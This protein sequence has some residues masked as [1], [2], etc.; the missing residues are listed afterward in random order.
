MFSGHSLIERGV[1]V[2]VES[3]ASSL[4]SSLVWNEQNITGSPMRA[5]TRGL[6]LDDPAFPGYRQGRNR[7]T[8]NMDI[9]A[10]LSNPQTTGGRRYDTLVIAERHD[11]VNTLMWEDT[12]RYARHYLE[13]MVA[14]NAA[15]NGYLYHAWLGI[16]DKNDPWQ[17][18]N[19]ERT[20]A[21]AWQC[22]AARV[23]V[24]LAAE[25]RAERMRYLPAGLALADLVDAAARGGVAGISAGSA[26]ATVDQL[27]TDALHPSALG[28]Y[29]LSLVTYASVY[30][31]SPVGAWAPQGVTAQQAA[32]LQQMAWQSV[33][34]HYNANAT[35]PSPSQCQAA[36][37]EQ[38]CTA[39]ASYSGNPNNAAGCIARFGEASQN[40]PFHYDAASDRAYWFPA[41]R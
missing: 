4:G 38:V 13:R 20:A 28:E 17:W 34:N 1:A 30:R 3:V 8:S 16:N 9:V 41:P 40:N 26:A 31:R 5:R 15:A 36:M 2:G 19:Y 32:A 25:G 11:I 12:V 10:E 23:N 33:S 39:Y 24:S 6:T 29:Y 27:F 18:V 21:R 14:G 35:E 7:W 22:A 37:R